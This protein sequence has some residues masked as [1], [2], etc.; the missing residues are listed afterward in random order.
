[1]ALNPQHPRVTQATLGEFH[2]MNPYIPQHTVSSAL[3]ACSD[4]ER[5]TL[6]A[7]D[8]LLNRVA[9]QLDRHAAGLVAFDVADFFLHCAHAAGKMRGGSCKEQ[10]LSRNCSR[11]LALKK[12]AAVC[13]NGSVVSRCPLHQHAVITSRCRQSRASRLG[14]QKQQAEQGVIGGARRALSCGLCGIPVHAR[15][16]SA[17]SMSGPT[18]VRC[19]WALEKGGRRQE[20]AREPL[21]WILGI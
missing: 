9:Q 13:G 15:D 12:Q 20:L 14:E 21:C 6:E 4:G 18:A 11:A 8:Q 5:R 1:M 19:Y 10:Q 3:T 2:A 16:R 7:A 17:S